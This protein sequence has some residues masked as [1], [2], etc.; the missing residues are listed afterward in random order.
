MNIL[1]SQSFKSDGHVKD[2]ITA[3]RLKIYSV[4]R[5]P[6][7]EA[8]EWPLLS[9]LIPFMGRC[10]M[11]SGQVETTIL[12]SMRISKTAAMSGFVLFKSQCTMPNSRMPLTQPQP[13][14]PIF[15]PSTPFRLQEH[16][17]L[18]EYMIICLLMVYLTHIYLQKR[19]MMQNY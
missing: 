2:G 11:E 19:C 18:Q 12:S 9:A 10:E 14:S 15:L 1:K 4:V 6:D 16:T 3:M 5:I 13:P 17:T 8:D 7:K